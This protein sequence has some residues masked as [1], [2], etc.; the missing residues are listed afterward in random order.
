MW[1]TGTNVAVSYLNYW[2]MNNNT[3]LVGFF[4]TDKTWIIVKIIFN[5]RVCVGKEYKLFYLNELFKCLF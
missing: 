5:L 3:H 4:I 2:I 1:H